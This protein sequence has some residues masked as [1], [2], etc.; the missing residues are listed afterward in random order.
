MEVYLEPS[1]T[2]Y[3]C[4]ISQGGSQILVYSHESLRFRIVKD[5]SQTPKR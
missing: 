1:Q 5:F 2:S 3:S 4:Q